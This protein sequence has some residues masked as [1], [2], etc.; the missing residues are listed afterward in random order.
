M[1]DNLTE[2]NEAWDGIEP[3]HGDV[4]ID[5]QYAAEHNLPPSI[6]HPRH[7]D[8]LLYIIESYHAIHCLVCLVPFLSYLCVWFLEGRRRLALANREF[9]IF[10]PLEA[11]PLSLFLPESWGALDLA[12]GTR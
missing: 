9:L 12:T 11:P 4:I 1:S 7:P 2:A 6:A 3:G 5:P 10:A 8:K